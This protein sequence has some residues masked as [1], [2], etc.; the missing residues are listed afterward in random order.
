MISGLWYKARA[1]KENIFYTILTVFLLERVRKRWNCFEEDGRTNNE[2]AQDIS[3]RQQSFMFRASLLYATPFLIP[4]VKYVYRSI[5]ELSG[6]VG[7]LLALNNLWAFG[8]VVV[9]TQALLSI[10]IYNL[11][12]IYVERMN[13]ALGL[14]KVLG[15]S[16]RDG[17]RLAVQARDS[18]RIRVATTV[19]GASSLTR[20]AAHS[21]TNRVLRLSRSGMNIARRLLRVGGSRSRVVEGEGS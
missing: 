3:R 2:T 1:N 19:R 4:T 16:V 20:S 14:F 6:Y 7:G 21:S 18:M 5:N 11:L 12:G 9:L 8:A 15:R 13:G 17:S 10:I